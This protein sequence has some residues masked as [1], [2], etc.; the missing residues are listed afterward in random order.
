MCG[1][2]GYFRM[3]NNL[4]INCQSIVSKMSQ[5]MLKRGP[6]SNGIW[7]SGNITFGHQRLSILDLDSRSD[8]PMLSSCGRYVIVFNG[9]IYNF[10]NLK[11]GLEKDGFVF[12]TSSDTEVLLALFVAKKENML[13]SLRGMFSF[14]IWDNDLDE[15]F[16]ARD[17]YGIKPLYYAS[18]E[19]GFLFASQVKALMSSGLISKKKELAALVGFYLWG[20]VPEPWT[21]YEGVYSVPA[22]H[23]M[24]VKNGYVSELVCWHD[25]TKHWQS[26]SKKISNDEL[27]EEIYLA[28][29]DS[30]Q[31][32]LVA[33]VPISIFLSGGVDSGILAGLIAEFKL[34]VEAITIGFKEF[35]GS[36]RDETVHAKHIA[37]HYGMSHHIKWV[38][39]HEFEED[40]PFILKAMDQPSIDGVNTWFAS[41]AAAERGYKLSLSGIGGDEL[42]CGYSSFQRI[43]KLL[44]L[45]K[46]SSKIM[47]NKTKFLD[48]FTWLA[49]QRSQPKIAGI[50]KYIGTLQGMYFLERSLFLASDLADLIGKEAS[51]EGLK[52]LGGD[53]PGMKQFKCRDG[54]STI[55]ALESKHYLRN[56]LL[57]DTDWASMS[58]S[59]ELRTPLVDIELLDK[60]GPFVSNFK[61]GNGKKNLSKAS[62]NPLPGSILNKPKSGFGLPIDK[63]MFS[64]SNSSL[65][66]ITNS[67]KYS[68]SSWARQW[69]RF[70]IEEF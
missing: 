59:L 9:E 34:P 45:G 1:I 47:S 35:V 31:S 39:Q 11:Y 36:K 7:S 6:D 42:F 38:S 51:T 23:W 43:T 52:R 50:P 68:S 53:P 54:L 16:L 55:A 24:K 65:Q 64:S 62:V 44:F 10:Q 33:D 70:V 69:A 56:Q 61:N 32:H 19:S 30:I 13:D 58:H 2:A 41:K 28:L 29:K 22:G 60:L 48:L 63:W 5:N 49:K 20:S 46:V 12:K 3:Q 18:I 4:E 67:S 40:L 21:I 66:S 57:K 27:Q 15:L 37:S 26:N 17:P 25:V 8:Q 14:A